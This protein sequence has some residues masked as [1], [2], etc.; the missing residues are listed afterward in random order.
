[1]TKKT[2]LVVGQGAREHALACRLLE[3]DAVG[4]VLVAPGNAG[5]DLGA[6]AP[7]GK[8]LASAAGDPREIALS[9][10]PDLIV[11]GPEAP[12]VAGL[13]D[14]LSSAG[15][16]VYGPSRAAARLEGSKAFLKDF[17]VRHGIRTGRYHI[18]RSF[19]EARE[20]IADFAVPPVIKADGLCAGKGVVVAATVGEAEDAAREMLSGRAF[21][22]AGRT[23]VIEE[24]LEGQE[25]SVH[26][27]CDGERA[28]LL[29]GVQ[30]HKRIGDGDTG[31][32]TGGMGTYGPVAWMDAE[33]SR[34]LQS[35][36]VE[37]VL[38]GMAE[39]GTP[40]KGTI[41]ANIMLVG[42]VDPVLFEINVRFGD[43]ET[44]VLMNVLRGDLYEALRGCALGRLD[45]DS[46][47]VDP[48]GPSAV[49]VVLA[50]SGYPAA[51][52]SG[53]VIEGLDRAARSPGVRIYHAGTRR[54]GGRVLTAG[55]RVLGVTAVAAD[56]PAARAR[57]YEAAEQIQFSGKQM[58]RDIGAR[59][60]VPRISDSGA[61]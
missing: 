15:L 45:P 59:A 12:L 42:G 40:F 31:P 23:V 24:R 54:D 14:E 28:L 46:L 20:Q 7:P 30:D 43:P 48:D 51:P 8:S 10:R 4:R 44:Q 13:V 35:G 16:A 6:G 57:A 37:P 49:C 36:V 56:L 29:P 33:L 9:L 53:D 19:D 61:T 55:G 32:N 17:A 34:R 26:A 39:L 52:R 38:R 5:S 11:V 3:S 25:L 47:R 50:A 21:G 22:D 41:F 60:L 1:V 27:I 18:A 2:V 58:R